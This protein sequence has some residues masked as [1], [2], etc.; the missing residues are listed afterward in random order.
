[1]QVNLGQLDEISEMIINIS[2]NLQIYNY[3][4]INNMSHRKAKLLL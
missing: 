2:F 4:F 1:M 3:S